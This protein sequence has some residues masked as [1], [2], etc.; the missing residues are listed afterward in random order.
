MPIIDCIP[1]VE[2]MKSLG[3]KRLAVEKRDLLIY[4]YVIVN[5]VE[6]YYLYH[7]ILTISGIGPAYAIEIQKK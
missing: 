1:T 4:I 6:I 2:F 7:W 5:Q 3:C